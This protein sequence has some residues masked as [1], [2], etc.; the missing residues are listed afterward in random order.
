MSAD[1]L[2]G[3]GTTGGDAE[4]ARGR[5]GQRTGAVPGSAAGASAREAPA[6]GAS[7]R[8]APAQEA[9]ARDAPARETSARGTPAREAP[10][11]EAPARGTPAREAPAREAPARGTPTR[12]VIAQDAPAREAPGPAAAPK[13]ASTPGAPSRG[14]PARDAAPKEPTG[15]R[16]SAGSPVREMLAVPGPN[17]TLVGNETDRQRA[18]ATPARAAAAPEPPRQ[19]PAPATAPSAAA[20]PVADSAPARDPSDADLFARYTRDYISGREGQQITVLQAGCTTAGGD[21]GIG[22]LRAAGA[23][24]AVSLIDDDQPATR[25]ALSTDESMAG[26]VHGDLRTLPLPPR[27]HD[28]VLCALLLQRIQNA[29]LVLDR[30]VATLRPGG[31]LLLRFSD[32]DSAAGFL[33]RVLPAAARR[34]VWR[35]RRPGQPGPYEAVYERLSSA[36]GIQAYALMRELVIAERR[37]LGGLAGGMAEPYGLLA[38]QKLIAW[39][40]RGRLTAAHEELLYVLRKPEDRFARVL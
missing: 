16:V 40:S 14:A 4:A 34:A 23:D 25:T 6:R 3:S 21:L 28:I 29:E 24:V 7:A 17:V 22:T 30:L 12:E 2:A 27:S 19:A 39:L 18:A 10:A 11:R 9:P 8:G 26:C 1:G 36:R 33:D 20:V 15:Q 38:G 31:L 32:R 37:A 35:K 5:R 13:E